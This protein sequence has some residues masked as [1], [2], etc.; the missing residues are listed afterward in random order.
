MSEYTALFSACLP[1]HRYVFG[2]ECST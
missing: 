2:K 1:L